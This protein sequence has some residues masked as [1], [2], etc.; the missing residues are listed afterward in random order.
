M[1]FKN[2][3]GSWSTIG[4]VSFGN[5]SC[6]IG[7]PTVFTRI[8][9]YIDWIQSV[10]YDFKLTTVPS[11]SSVIAKTTQTTAKP[12]KGEANSITIPAAMI[13]VCLLVAQQFN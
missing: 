4:I 11:T 13:I 7:T 1:N 5:G 8:G 12:Y 2:P 9:P 3:D 10:R 6:I